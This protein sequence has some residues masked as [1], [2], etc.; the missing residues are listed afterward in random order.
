MLTTNRE[1]PRNMELNCQAAIGLNISV[2]WKIR[3]KVIRFV[4]RNLV[5]YLVT[6]NDG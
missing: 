6:G 1:R 2:R 4:R 3:R 5:R